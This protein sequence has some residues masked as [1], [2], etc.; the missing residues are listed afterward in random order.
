MSVLKILGG[1]KR[2]M[3]FPAA[4]AMLGICGAGHVNAQKLPATS[5]SPPC[6]NITTVQVL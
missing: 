6:R 4:V 5:S 1:A 2:G 3:L